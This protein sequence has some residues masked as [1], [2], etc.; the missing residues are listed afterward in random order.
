MARA[1][2][3]GVLRREAQ[4]V[5]AVAASEL[6]PGTASEEPVLVQ[7]VIDAWFEEEGELVL[8]DYKTDHIAAEEELKRRY[9]VQLGLYARALQMMEGKKPSEL[10]LWSFALGRAI[11]L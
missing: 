1:M 8:V 5:M 3:R 4:F 9:R 7:G 2:Q 11:R 6:D 10:L